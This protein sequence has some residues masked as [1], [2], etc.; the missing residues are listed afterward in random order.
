MYCFFFSS[1]EGEET[2]RAKSTSIT[3]G[4]TDLNTA[5]LLTVLYLKVPV[6]STVLIISRLK[7]SLGRMMSYLS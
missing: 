3:Q 4:Y 7:N 1:S 6:F 5:K 2:L